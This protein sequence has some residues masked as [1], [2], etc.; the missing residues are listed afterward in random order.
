MTL[1]AEERLPAAYLRRMREVL[2]EEYH[3]YLASFSEEPA[4]SLRRRGSLP[5]ESLFRAMGG[6]LPPVP[7]TETGYYYRKEMRPARSPY[8]AAGLYYLQE[9]SAMAPA[10]V[11]P[12][13]PGDR[14]LDLCAAPGGKATRLGE[15]LAGS[16]FLYANDISASRARSLLKN[17]ELAGLPNLYVTA[18]TPERL[19]EHFPNFFDRI[20]VDAPC[21]G[22]G[23]FRRTPSMVRDWEERGPQYYA[24]LQREILARAV[25]MLKPGGHLLYST[26]TFSREEDEENVEALLRD[27]PELTPDPEEIAMRRLPGVSAGDLPGTLRLWPH[28]LRGEG[29][30]L[31]LLR[32]RGEPAPAEEPPRRRREPRAPHAAMTGEYPAFAQSLPVRLTGEG[33]LHLQGEAL[34]LLPEGSAVLPGLR[35]QRTGL[36]LGEIRKGRFT[37]SQALAM[38]L[39][40]GEYPQTADFALGDPDVIRYLKGESVPHPGPNGW[41]LVTVDGYPLGWTK[42]Q[43]GTLKNKYNPAWRWQ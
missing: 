31:A 25:S 36:K 2:G 12:V 27:F 40:P 43:N 4:V 41:T 18:E 7:W 28:R 15:K 13:R 8:Y 29:H 30:F 35:Y 10:E 16:G 9:A 32:K 37:P 23:M 17:L 1:P 22:E 14:V 19:A 6:L 3:D 38:A 26:C 21:S 11:L 33:T 42:A 5:E 20:L 34:Y 24:P 39:R